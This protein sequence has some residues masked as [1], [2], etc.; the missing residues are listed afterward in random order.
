MRK[1]LPIILLF[2]LTIIF[3]WESFFLTKVFYFGD[4]FNLFI[5]NKI[6]FIN[7]VK[8]GIFPLWNPLILAGTPYIADLGIFPFYPGNLFFLFFSPEIALMVLAI[9]EVFLAGLFMKLYLKTLGFD[10]Y[11]SLLGGVILM[12]SGSVISHIGNISILNVIIWLPLILYFLEKSFSENS[13]K[14]IF[15]TSLFL[16]ISFLGGHLQLF[17]YNFIFLLIYLLFKIKADLRTKIKKGFSILIL[18]FLFSSFQI[19]PF[20]E[21]ASLSTRP[22]ADFS[23]S[24]EGSINPIITLRFFLAEVYGRLKDGYSWGPGAPMERGYADVT[25][26]FGF[27]PL[28]LVFWVILDR[29]R[30]N[31][32]SFWLLCFFLFLILSFGKFTPLYFLFFKFF[33]FFSRFRNPTQFLFLSTFSG[34]LVMVYALENI[35]REKFSKQRLIKI[36][37]YLFI[38]FSFLFLT[39]YLKT[40]I[41][42]NF[43]LNLFK[44]I[45][46]SI[47]NRP[48]IY[49]A[50]YNEEKLKLILLLLI[51][52][53]TIVSFLTLALLISFLKHFRRILRWAIFILI[54]L[55]LFLFSKNSLFLADKK[56]FEI[57]N[58]AV[59]F[60]KKNLKNGERYLSA[61]EI[62]PYTGLFN[63]WNQTMVRMPFGESR[64]NAKEIKEFPVLKKEAAV[65]PPD[66]GMDFNLLTV[67][68]YGTMVLKDYALFFKQ[69]KEKKDINNIT[70]KDFND[71]KLSELGIKYLIIDREL[72]KEQREIENA[73]NFKLVFSGK[74]VKIYRAGKILPRLFVLESGRLTKVEI[75]SY[76]P[77]E[78]TIAVENGRKGNLVLTDNYYPG[79][80]VFLD[81]KKAKIERYKN[82]FRLVKIDENTKEVV[83]KFR[84]K[85]LYWGVILSVFSLILCFLKLVRLFVPKTKN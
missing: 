49:P 76:Q 71:K 64:V 78:I 4:N 3:F 55:D 6:F 8:K 65:L 32:A 13:F 14:N 35:L 75:K 37:L 10:N 72:T 60:L 41:K 62:I 25:G 81:G 40:I 69:E 70:I 42:Q 38:F 61:S 11:L 53:L 48:F 12:F 19:L 50:A 59:V 77:N 74:F 80:E 57:P 23:Y 1:F 52:N 83:F 29:K 73:K 54:F 16:T 79:W 34:V 27:I 21:F 85:I 31:G 51:R 84:P 39:I 28:I 44:V 22:V 30:R 2:I 43:L 46:Q 20:L 66:L 56:A 17:Y 9:V 26:Y 82:T 24:T 63:Y 58:E 36:F 45:Y 5:P 47:T 15:L 33:P 18:F 7:E 68:G 67:N